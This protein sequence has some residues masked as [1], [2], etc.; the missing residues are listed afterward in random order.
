M[1]D[2]TT[3]CKGVDKGGMPRDGHPVRVLAIV[4]RS[5]NLTPR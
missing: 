5:D 2:K 3:D 1:T 4:K